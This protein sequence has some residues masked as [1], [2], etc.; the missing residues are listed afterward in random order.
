MP[1]I[2][3]CSNVNLNFPKL[4]ES[5]DVVVLCGSF[6]PMYDKNLLTWNITNQSD[7]I[8]EKLNPWLDELP[9]PCKIIV[10]GRNDH[11]AEFYGGNLSNYIHAEYVQDYVIDCKGLHIYG[12]PWMPNYLKSNDQKD[13][14]LCSSAQKYLRAIDKIPS[15]TNVLVTNTFP[16]EGESSE[17]EADFALANKMDKLEKLQI[18][19]HS[20]VKMI[21]DAEYVPKRYVSVQ[22]PSSADD[23]FAI[24]KV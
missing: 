20:A 2:A 17:E 1:V 8:R 15:F 13:A 24:I 23:E 7:F 19:I 11:I 6:C 10:G 14:F 9:S 12:T 22:A 21:E 5:V 3:T 16:R 18:H 4:K